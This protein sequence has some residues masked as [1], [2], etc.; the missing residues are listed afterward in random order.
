M[1][2]TILQDRD[3]PVPISTEMK[4]LLGEC[5]ALRESLRKFH[6]NS[7]RRV[8]FKLDSRWENDMP[9]DDSIEISKQL[10]IS[11]RDWSRREAKEFSQLDDLQGRDREFF[12]KEVAK[13]LL[14]GGPDKQ[15][16]PKHLRYPKVLMFILGALL[17]HH[18]FKTVYL[19]PFFFLGEE[20]SQILNDIMSL[21]NICRS[22]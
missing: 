1:A 17:T 16:F 18:I 7:P 5:D 19:D 8:D 12:F 13:I 21:G 6:V 2:V 4:L 20:T 14:L 10:D 22:F 11:I 9:D 15:E 3:N